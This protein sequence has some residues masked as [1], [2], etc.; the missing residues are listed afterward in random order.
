MRLQIEVFPQVYEPQTDTFLLL[1]QIQPNPDDIV[2]EL[3]CGCGVIALHLALAAKAVYAVDVNPHACVNTR[4]NAQVNGVSNLIIKQS[5]LYQSVAHQR[6]SLICANPP[7]LPT[8]PDYNETQIIEKSWN[9][10]PDGRRVIDQIIAELPNY[11]LSNGRFIMV[12]SSLAGI[13]KTENQLY[14]LGFSTRILAQK[15]LPLGPI[16]RGRYEWLC[17]RETFINPEAELLVVIE[18]K[19]TGV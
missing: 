9:A 4:H 10:G 11:L 8:P 6:F 2:L 5:R 7:Y 19:R 16:S 18:A 17:Q 3:G 15:W 14:H 1:K 13:A 12:Q